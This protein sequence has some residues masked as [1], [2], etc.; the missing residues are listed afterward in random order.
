MLASEEAESA[1]AIRTP[2]PANGV[3]VGGVCV[4]LLVL[5]SPGEMQRTSDGVS[6]GQLLDR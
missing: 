6:S 2:Y 5:D 3:P 1:W 4:V